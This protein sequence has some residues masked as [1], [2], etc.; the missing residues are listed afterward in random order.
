MIKRKFREVNTKVS[1]RPKTV[2]SGRA[3]SSII[4][5]DLFKLCFSIFLF[6]LPLEGDYLTRC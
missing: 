4:N 2:E 5:L 6:F 3:S 1:S